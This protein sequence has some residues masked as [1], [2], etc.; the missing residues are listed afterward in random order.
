MVQTMTQDQDQPPDQIEAKFQPALDIS[1]SPVNYFVIFY[2]Y[3]MKHQ[4]FLAPTW[5]QHYWYIHQQCWRLQRSKQIPSH[6]ETSPQLFCL[7]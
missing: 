3:S 1:W 5:V 6:W 7:L 2:Y 4:P